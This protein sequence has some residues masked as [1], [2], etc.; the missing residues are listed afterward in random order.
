MLKRFFIFLVAICLL[1]TASPVAAQTPIP[2]GPIYIVQPSDNSLTDIA[3][4]FNVSLNDLISANGIANPNLIFPGQQLVIPG[5]DGVTGI[6]DTEVVN[7]GDSFHSLVRR[8]QVAVPLLRK[9]NRLVSPSEFYVGA[10]MIIPKQDNA[11]DLSNRFIPAAGESLLEL[12]V[13]QNTDP[14]TVTVLN[15]LNGTWDAL[16]GDVLY[17]QGPASNQTASGL[18][19]AFVS[20][21]ITS[22]PLKQGS[23]A[24][25]IV[26]PA[27]GVTISGTLITYPLHF[28][29]L[30]DGRMVALQGIHAMLD[31]GVYPLHLDATSADG[32]KQS[33]EQ[34]VLIV[35]GD[36][37]TV[38]IPVPPEDPTIMESENQQVASVVSQATSIKYWQGKFNLPVGLPFCIKD[39]F[40]TPRDLPFNGNMYHYFHG[41][42]DY[43]V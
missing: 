3:I 16:P 2:S 10:S 25:L 26:R 11:T 30:G 1:F 14:W 12:A 6:L 42:V 32:S 18:P 36:Q 27:D 41:G 24:E 15:D 9:L 28:F 40:G 37:P 22:L 33:F 21:E 13:K 29:P 31:P 43:G 17:T 23:T 34:M 5:L 39:W 19:S 38:A 8:T 4:R 7:F 35:L 20:A